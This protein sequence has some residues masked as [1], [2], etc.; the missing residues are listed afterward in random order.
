MGYKDAEALMTFY[1]NTPNDTLGIFWFP[2]DDKKP[3]FSREMDIQ[4]GWKRSRDEK[5]TRRRERY[6]SKF[7]GA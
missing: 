4:P 3:I 5:N 2:I 6:E 1:N 7:R